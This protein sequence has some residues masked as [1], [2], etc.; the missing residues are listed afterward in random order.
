MMKKIFAIA[1]AL[2]LCAS[3]FAQET[4]RDEN[5]RIKYGPY[6][7][8]KFWDNWFIGA[9][10]GFNAHVDGITNLL[11]FERPDLARGGAPAFQL[12]AGKWLE[13]CYGLRGGLQGYK[14]G[15]FN[16]NVKFK[17]WSLNADFLVNISNLFWG[18]KDGRKFNCS[19]YVSA[20][21]IFA[22][23]HAFGV[24]AGLYNTYGINDKLDIFLDLRTGLAPQR[25]TG[26]GQNGKILVNTGT[27][28]IA[29]KFAKR[30]WQRACASKGDAAA[31]AAAGKAA[32]K[33]TQ[34]ELEE[35]QKARENALNAAT[36]ANNAA[37][38]ANNAAAAANAA[39]A[40]ALQ[41][42]KQNPQPA[43]QQAAPAQAAPAQQAAPAPQQA[44]PAQAAPA[45][46]AEPAP[47]APD[48]K[49]QQAIQDLKDVQFKSGLP[50]LDDR[51]KHNLDVVAEYLKSNPS[52][53]I[54]VAGHT[55]STGNDA[56]NNPLSEKR[57]KVVADYLKEQ[58]VNDSQIFVKGYGSSKPIASN[59]TVEGRQQNRRVELN[60]L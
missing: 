46:Q 29:Y 57:A 7:T 19:P 31:A 13:P 1:V 12:F 58:G 52:V 17:Y 15:Y 51:A 60:V 3:A 35:L 23:G 44:A 40:A 55:D 11:K 30:N 14:G 25:I 56:I 10:I 34:E 36:A 18:Y 4:N 41:E 20:M 39:T 59:S 22:E 6:A 37:A 24:G 26:A 27:L 33:A 43:Q 45:Q 42:Q 9:G 21:A 32:P 2:V 47:A 50:N 48:E 38:A 54:E 28:G 5:G 49:V 8:N 16:D 53:K